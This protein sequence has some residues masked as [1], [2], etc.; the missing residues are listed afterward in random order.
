MNSWLAPSR[1]KAVNDPSARPSPTPTSQESASQPR[2]DAA[3]V[4]KF[5]HDR[6]RDHLGTRYALPA[7]AATGYE[8]WSADGLANRLLALTQRL[9]AQMG[10]GQAPAVVEDARNAV[11]QG[12]ADTRAATTRNAAQDAAITQT[13]QA[14]D[15][16]LEALTKQ[17]M[18]F[19]QT[20]STSLKLVTREGDVVTLDIARRTDASYGAV[21]S[22]NGSASVFS[23]ASEM[24]VNYTVKGDLNDQ[25]L[26]AIDNILGKLDGLTEQSL[27]QG[28]SALQDVLGRMMKDNP[29]I[30]QMSVNVASD[31][32]YAM[33]VQGNN[34]ANDIASLR[35]MFAGLF[36]GTQSMDAIIAKIVE[37]KS[38]T[39][40]AHA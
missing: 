2:H 27:H 11:A 23:Y 10:P 4:H 5:M 38:P 7:P 32:H 33:A 6:V 3:A 1:G 29:V 28:G 13:Q 9:I 8:N 16:G 22:K 34:A 19:Q 37:A 31:T 26:A 30:G 21:Q 40:N 12:A 14:V 15:K 24:A 20:Q 25:E 18:A 35:D 36:D 39:V 17:G